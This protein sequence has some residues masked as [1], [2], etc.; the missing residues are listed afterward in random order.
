MKVVFVAGS[1]SSSLSGST[2]SSPAGSS[3]MIGDW[4]L[5]DDEDAPLVPSSSPPSAPSTRSSAR[6]VLSALGSGICKDFRSELVTVP[7]TVTML[8]WSSSV[9]PS[10]APGTLLYS[11]R[12]H[13]SSL[14]S[15]TTDPG[16]E[17]LSRIG[18]LALDLPGGRVIPVNVRHGPRTVG[19]V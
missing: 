1:S 19:A 17:L 14:L 8:D 12:R 10:N 13:G 18:S 9:L 3:G 4:T 5:E 15:W 7:E 16:T 2:L 6:F 11:I